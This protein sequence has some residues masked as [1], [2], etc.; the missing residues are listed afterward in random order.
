MDDTNDVLTLIVPS[1]PT[2]VPSVRDHGGHQPPTRGVI[3]RW[4]GVEQKVDI[5]TARANL[6]RCL[7]QIR[8]M[9]L[10]MEQEAIEGWDL[11]GLSV[12]LAIS[13]E[14]SRLS[15]SWHSLRA[16]AAARSSGSWKRISTSNRRC[17]HSR[18][19]AV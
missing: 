9:L 13:A 11:D 19:S 10:D 12:S 16:C 8:S 15:T 17:P 14:G 3:Q 1:S 2:Q 7:Q 6:Q 18:S 5:D 4:L